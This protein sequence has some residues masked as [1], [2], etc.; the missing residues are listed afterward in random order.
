LT[1]TAEDD[2]AEIWVYLALEASQRRASEI[3]DERNPK[4]WG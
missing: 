3:A 1:E 2:L 4:A